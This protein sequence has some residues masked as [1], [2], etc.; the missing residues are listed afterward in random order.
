MTDKPSI[1]EQIAAVQLEV[2]R[3]ENCADDWL[4][5]SNTL[6]RESIGHR[7]AIISLKHLA[8]LRAVL[9][10]LQQHERAMA[11]VEAARY[12]FTKQK[13]RAADKR[14]ATDNLWSAL[15]ALDA[16]T[17]ETEAK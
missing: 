15:G 1:A 8:A 14:K 7:S 10:T 11:V 5:Y 13:W 2:S 3:M 17:A 6:P 12:M 16:A 4:L 9:A